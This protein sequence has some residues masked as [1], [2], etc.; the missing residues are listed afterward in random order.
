MV[1]YTGTFKNNQKDG[2]TC[3][4][5][6]IGDLQE[7]VEYTGGFKEDK[8]FGCGVILFRSGYL[9]KGDFKDGLPY[10]GI[11]RYPTGDEYKGKLTVPG[12]LKD[13]HGI[14]SYKN[15]DYFC[16]D[17]YKDKKHGKGIYKKASGDTVNG[18]WQDDKLEMGQMVY[19]D[20]DYFGSFDEDMQPCGK[21]IFQYNNGEALY[22]GGW[23]NGL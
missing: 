15:G 4:L 6:A 17:F 20:G 2:E 23:K 1:Q 7:I 19:P 8:F 10:D 9:F 14:L 22:Q 18:V 5:E 12:M 11:M 3:T 13:G 16:G 21:G